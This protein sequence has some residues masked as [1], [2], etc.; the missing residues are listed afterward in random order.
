MNT[1][2]LTNVL[3]GGDLHAAYFAQML[4]RLVVAALLGAGVAYRPW[5]KLTRGEPP[6]PETAQA[7][8]LIAVAG[9]IMV[10]V[11]GDSTA[12]AFGLVGLGGFIR[13]RS[14]I[15]DPREA[16]IM[17]VMIGLGMACGL[18]AV[19]VAIVAAVFAAAVLA[20]FDATAKTRP[21]PVRVGLI[22][23]EPRTAIP[24]IRNAFPAVRILDVPAVAEPGTVI[25]QFPAGR[26]LDAG[27]LLVILDQ[28]GIRG[29]TRVTLEED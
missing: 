17:F 19:P 29:I 27:S 5:R 26:D 21:Q 20:F 7:Q 8:T 16:A 18:G 15:K 9:A 24:L 1:F 13:F 2:D 12:R 3:G 4:V 23:D 10:A 22:V 28:Q 25:L 14:G 11:I 6:A